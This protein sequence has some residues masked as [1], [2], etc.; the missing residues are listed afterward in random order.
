MG[1]TDAV[2]MN[3][4]SCPASLTATARSRA[5]TVA[6]ACNVEVG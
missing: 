5:A 1:F 2:W 3:P 4:A 6:H